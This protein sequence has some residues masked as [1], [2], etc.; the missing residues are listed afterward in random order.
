MIVMIAM[1]LRQLVER[2]KGLEDSSTKGTI[3]SSKSA[4]EGGIEHYTIP[5]NYIFNLKYT[6]LP[7]NLEVFYSTLPCQP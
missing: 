6:I 2:L 7:E 5:M 1:L 4:S 3:L